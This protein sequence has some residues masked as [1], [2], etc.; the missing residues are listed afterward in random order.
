MLHC[1]TCLHLVC[2]LCRL[3]LCGFSFL[4]IFSCGCSFAYVWMLNLRVGAQ[5]CTL[6]MSGVVWV[7]GTVARY[8][9]FLFS[10]CGEA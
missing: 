7:L 3:R 9:E 10:M 6:R 5:A 4:F 1:N 2:H 8:L